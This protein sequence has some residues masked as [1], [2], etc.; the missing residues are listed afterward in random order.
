MCLELNS[1][2]LRGTGDEQLVI[3]DGIFVIS[4]MYK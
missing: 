4:H 1:L 3:H 2:Q